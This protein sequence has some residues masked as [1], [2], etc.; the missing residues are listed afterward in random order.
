LSEGERAWSEGLQAQTRE[1]IEDPLIL[2]PIE[3]IHFKNIHRRCG[4]IT[5]DELCQN[6]LRMIDS[7]TG[8]ETIYANADELIQA[9]WALD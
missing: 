1:A 6:K 7:K 4:T 9:G 5:F 8:E 2:P 3:K